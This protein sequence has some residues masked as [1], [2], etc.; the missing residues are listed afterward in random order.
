MSL[1]IIEGRP[2]VRELQARKRDIKLTLTEEGHS[3]ADQRLA[4]ETRRSQK[5]MNLSLTLVAGKLM[6]EGTRSNATST[7]IDGRTVTTGMYSLNPIRD[8]SES[9]LP[10]DLQITG[11]VVTSEVDYRKVDKQSASITLNTV[12]H[13]DPYY[14][15]GARKIPLY[16]ISGSWTNGLAQNATLTRADG[17]LVTEPHEQAKIA[18]RILAYTNRSVKFPV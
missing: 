2:I 12:I 5:K 6:E 16:T 1:N 15:Q 13:Y 3:F 14:P 7:Q 18:T 9:G 10:D 17:S 8:Y 11:T 4:E